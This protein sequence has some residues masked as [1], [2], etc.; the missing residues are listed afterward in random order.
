VDEWLDAG[1]RV[2]VLGDFNDGPSM[3]FE[4]AQ[5]TRLAVEIVMGDA[6]APERLLRNLCPRPK[7]IKQG[8]RPSTA[9]YQDPQ[10]HL[11]AHALTDHILFSQNVTASDFKIWNP[12]EDDAARAIRDGLLE[13]SN[14]FPVSID[15]KAD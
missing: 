8:W 15:I 7:W 10:T 4:T 9:R 11:Y 13:A 14:H 5:T 2:V 6:F 3:D 12:Y 1:E